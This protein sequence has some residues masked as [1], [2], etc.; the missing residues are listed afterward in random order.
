M[1]KPWQSWPNFRLIQE[2]EKLVKEN[3][4]LKEISEG[5]TKENL[6]LS[7]RLYVATFK[8]DMGH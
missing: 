2:Y 5:L 6:Q 4:Q 3:K 1:D 8:E 7:N